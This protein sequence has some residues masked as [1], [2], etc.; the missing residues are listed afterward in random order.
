[1]GVAI[2]AAVL[3]VAAP[4]L[5]PALSPFMMG[6]V[7]G[8]IAGAGIGGFT[9]GMT[10]GNIGMGMLTGAISGAIFG[11]IGGF[12]LGTTMNPIAHFAGGAA[13]G[14]IGAEITGGNVGVNALIG[15]ISAGAGQWAGQSN[16]IFHL[17][18]NYIQ[19][20]V[21]QAALGGII[22]GA[23]SAAFG[24]SFKSGFI[25]GAE[26]SAIG[27]TSNSFV[28][29]YAP[30]IV[31]GILAGASYIPGP[32]GAGARVVRTVLSAL[33]VGS[34]VLMLASKTPNNLPGN[35]VENPNRPGSFGVYGPDGK[36]TER[37]RFDEGKSGMPG[38]RGKD[39]V[40]VDG[41]KDHLPPDTPYP[42]N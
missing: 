10:G 11:G 27:Y 2:A 15:G 9:A 21:R 20:V 6:V 22:G 30:Q 13:S 7:Q 23:T 4:Y 28:H 1:M 16:G 35:A 41:G 42:E 3:F 36:F 8:A 32:V 25:N 37:W 18:G 31:N 12:H 26:M 39:H 33:S 17:T 29:D 24:G 5:A 14:A 19:D 40:H 38:W 34:E